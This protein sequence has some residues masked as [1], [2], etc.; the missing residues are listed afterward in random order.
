VLQEREFERVGGSVS[1][2]ID[3]RVISATNK[4]L[5]QE[6]EAGR[7][8]EDLYYR[9]NVI[10]IYLPPLR[11]RIEDI[12][13]LVEHFIGKH[14][15]RAGEG[16]SRISQSAVRLL[17]EYHWPGNVR[18]LENVIERAV[19]LSQGGLITG[20][21]IDLAGADNRRFLDIAQAVRKGA[22]LSELLANVERQAIQEALNQT[23]GDRIAAAALLQVDLPSFQER[24]AATGA[25]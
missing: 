15:F 14:R 21:H 18:Q 7:F 11:D 25:A 20:E 12:P 8:R 6:I 4:V 19:V 3:T 16:P 17:M 1:V 9:L 10:A 13:L 23:D 5:P 2:K 24:L 22:S